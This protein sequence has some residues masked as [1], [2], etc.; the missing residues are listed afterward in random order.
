M[1]NENNDQHQQT[2]EYRLAHGDPSAWLNWSPEYLAPQ[3]MLDAWEEPLKRRGEP[4]FPETFHFY[5]HFPYCKQS[6]SFCM[7][8]HKV[9]QEDATY[10][11]YADYL[12]ERLEQFRTRYGKVTISNAY[13]GGGT[14]SAMPP[15]HLKRYLDAL[16]ATFEIRHEF[17]V[18]AHPIT[19]SD[20]LLHTLHGAGVNRISM[21][22]QSTDKTVLKNITRRN[23]PYEEIAS[24]VKAATAKGIAV[25]LDLCI[26]LPEQTREIVAHDLKLITNM[27][28]SRITLYPYHPVKSLPINPPDELALSDLLTDTNQE[29]GEHRPLDPLARAAGYNNISINR[30]QAILQQTQR[31]NAPSRHP[32]STDEQH[33]TCFSDYPSHLLGLGPASFNHIFGHSWSR[34]VTGLEALDASNPSQ[35]GTRLSLQDETLLMFLNRLGSLQSVNTSAITKQ[36]GVDPCEIYS[37][38]INEGINQGWLIASAASPSFGS[39][40]LNPKLPEDERTRF[41]SSFVPQ[42]TWD[43]AETELPP[44]NDVEVQ[45]LSNRRKKPRKSVREAITQW[46]ELLKVPLAGRKFRGAWVTQVDDA[47]VCFGIEG[48]NASPLRVFLAPRGAQQGFAES[49]RF[50][51]SHQNKPLSNKEKAFFLKLVEQTLKLDPPGTSLTQ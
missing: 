15:K 5:T 42:S 6:C 4:G 32:H 8:W 3:D 46:R 28:P 29:Q 40:R 36:T 39:L 9:P 22:I 20:D 14:P 50:V 1:A 33:Y 13:F 47:S 18:E 51:I 19:L 48:R 31:E 27:R 34:E 24:F 25:N 43:K 30:F 35:A 7:Y 44:R 26:G 16:Q 21:G 49:R 23:R 10:R 38:Q 12:I 37:T 17:T 11:D 45:L 2:L 41:L